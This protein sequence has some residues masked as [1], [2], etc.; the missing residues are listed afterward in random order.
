LLIGIITSSWALA[1]AHLDSLIVVFIAA[2]LLP[3]IVVA[4]LDLAMRRRRDWLHWLGV[5]TLAGTLLTA[6]LSEVFRG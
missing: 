6:L 2:M 1:S 5:F 3:L 4:L